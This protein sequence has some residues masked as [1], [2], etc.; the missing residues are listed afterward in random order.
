MTILFSLENLEKSRKF[1]LNMMQ[2]KY[3]TINLYLTFH[4]K[5]KL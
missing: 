2:F 3:Y 4:A 1:L 5:Q